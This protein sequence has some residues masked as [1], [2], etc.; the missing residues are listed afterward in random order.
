MAQ[1]NKCLTSPS[2]PGDIITRANGERIGCFD[3][4][5]PE[6]CCP[7]ND[8]LVGHVRLRDLRIKVGLYAKGGAQ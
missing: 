8:F 2:H 6:E 4:A 1:V 7:A 5:V 3:G